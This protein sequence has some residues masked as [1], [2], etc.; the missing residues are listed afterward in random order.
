MTQTQTSVPAV[1][2][3]GLLEGAD[4]KNR[5]SEILGKNAPAFISSV[6]SAVNSSAALKAAEPNTVV[7]SAMMAAT[8][9]LPINANL[10]FAHIIPYK[11]NF[12]DA[13]GNWQSKTVAQFQM[14][15]R[16]FVQLAIRT[17]LYDTINV[18][19]IYQNQFKGFNVL[20]GEIEF[21]NVIGEGEIIGYAAHYILRTGFHK[22]FYMNVQ[23]VRAHGK[24]YS[25]SY[26]NKD[27]QWAGN[28]DAMAKK[29]VL[30]LLLSRWGMLSIEMRNALTADQAVIVNPDNA[31]YKYPD[32]PNTPEE[33]E[34]TEEAAHEVV[35]T[36]TTVTANTGIVPDA[37][38]M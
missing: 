30:K 3:K 28:F 9:D 1:T 21:N 15:W 16:G 22:T 13:Q 37:A 34:T 38:D 23:Q 7:M 17:G 25:K 26:E 32:N 12:K 36:T 5:I 14:G 27:G 2:V 11:Q 18:T 31:D 35:E 19:E 4:I 20:S 24:K 10:G 8:L 6:I 29:T 33:G